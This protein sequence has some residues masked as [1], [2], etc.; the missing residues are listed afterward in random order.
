MAFGSYHR[1]SADERA[2]FP[3]PGEPEQLPLFDFALDVPHD[4]SEEFISSQELAVTTRQIEGKTI[5]EETKAFV[6]DL[7]FSIV[8]AILVIVFVVQPVRVEG[9]SMLPHLHNG[10]RIFI[11]KFIYRFD[12]IERGDIVVFWYPNDPDKSFIKRVIGL[13]GETVAIRNGVVYINGQPLDE[14]YLDPRY[15]RRHENMPS[16]FIRN[17]YYF[18]MGDNRDASND[19]RQWGPV[20]EKYIYGKAIFRYWPPGNVGTIK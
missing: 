1:A 10:E 11:N 18:V 17:H 13:P 9:T 12:R 15:H 19:S 7:L 3:R 6:R 5:W 8:V 14:P 4:D 16:T 2:P 20:P